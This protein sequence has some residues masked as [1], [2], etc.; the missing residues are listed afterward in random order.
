M[1][2]TFESYLA[3]IEKTLKPMAISER[4]DI[5]LE[6]ESE[7]EEMIAEGKSE[8]EIKERLGDPKELARAYLQ[9]A[10]IK[11]PSFSLKKLGAL[12]AFYGVAGSIWLFVLPITGTFA[13]SFMICGILAPIAGIIKFVG[14]LSGFEVPWVIMQIGNYQMSA[15]LALPFTLLMGIL[16]Y[17]LGKACWKLTLFLIRGISQNKARLEN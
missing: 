5:L 12:V 10:L 6:I 9:E 14:H 11:E 8:V 17:F 1:E 3:Q 13:V 2:K 4:L 15:E 7:I 16:F